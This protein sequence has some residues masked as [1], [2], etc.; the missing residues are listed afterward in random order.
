MKEVADTHVFIK[1]L[2]SVM[3]LKRLLVTEKGRLDF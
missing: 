1:D 2:V 3:V